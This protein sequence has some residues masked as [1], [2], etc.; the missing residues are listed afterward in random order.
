MTGTNIFPD[1]APNGSLPTGSWVPFV[2]QASTGA[3][4]RYDLGADLLNR[5]SYTALAAATGSNLSG[6]AQAG[7]GAIDTTVQAELRK[8]LRASN[9]T[10][11][12]QAVDQ[13]EAAG[14]DLL[15]DTART[16]AAN[17]TTTARLIPDGGV[18]TTGAFNLSVS[19]IEGPE[20]PLFDKAGS[21]TITIS[22][23]TDSLLGWFSPTADGTADDTNPVTRWV[24]SSTHRKTTLVGQIKTDTVDVPTHLLDQTV[25]EGAGTRATIFVSKDGDDVFRFLGVDSDGLD[26]VNRVRVGNFGVV[27]QGDSTGSGYAVHIPST[28]STGRYNLFHDIDA[29]QMGGGCIKDASAG[30]GL[31]ATEWVRCAGGESGLNVFEMAGGGP[32]SIMRECY[33]RNCKA[34]KIGFRVYRSNLVLESCGGLDVNTAAGSLLAV[35]GSSTSP[36]VID[37]TDYGAITIPAGLVNVTAAN[38]VRSLNAEAF[39]DIAIVC[40]N[41][42]VYLDP[43]CVFQ[44]KEDQADCIAIYCTNGIGLGVQGTLPP[45]GNFLLIGTATWAQGCPVWVQGT[46]P[47]FV[48]PVHNSGNNYLDIRDWQNDITIR[49]SAMGSAYVGTTSE[50]LFEEFA[51]F[52]GIRTDMFRMEA[53]TPAS[54]GAAGSAGQWA[55]DASYIYVCTA[56]NTWKRVAIATW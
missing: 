2:D 47:A 31:F 32:M 9:Y 4:Q 24:N 5:V 36:T 30:G 16:L 46:T 52:R 8:V 50:A 29:T 40:I 51:S 14:L 55:A 23:N 20:I 53:F 35:F 15:V 42:T 10:T 26:Y 18:I 17:L 44:T 48:P 13:A 33:A 3:N 41:G 7:A 43:G 37:E 49:L 39:P 56:N 21:G 28:V 6:Y 27:G 54:A 34:Q 1:M 38:V 45:T 19:S 11:F 25:L 12:V 22:E